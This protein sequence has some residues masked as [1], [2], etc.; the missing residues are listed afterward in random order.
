[1]SEELPG[2][3]QDPSALSTAIAVAT[4]RV[5]VQGL[6][7]A[8][9]ELKGDIRVEMRAGHLDL[10]ARLETNRVEIRNMLAESQRKWEENARADREQFVTAL[11]IHSQNFTKL[12]EIDRGQVQMERADNKEN[13][14][15]TTMLMTGVVILAALVPILLQLW[16]KK[17]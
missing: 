8:L 4:M 14:R 12:M 6:G 13:T 3:P 9:D 1:V 5:Q 7:K 10:G 16:L 2:L 11:H 17:P 15:K